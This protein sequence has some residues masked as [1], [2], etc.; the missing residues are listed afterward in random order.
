[1]DAKAATWQHCQIGYT[2]LRRGL[3]F[4][5]ARAAR[6]MSNILSNFY[7]NME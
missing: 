2:Y 7:K 1:M 3:K 5:D 4:W 6:E